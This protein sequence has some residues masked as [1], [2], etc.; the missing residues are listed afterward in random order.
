MDNVGSGSSPDPNPNVLYSVTKGMYFAASGSWHVGW[1]LLAPSVPNSDVPSSM[2]KVTRTDSGLR[3]TEPWYSAWIL[4]IGRGLSW[5]VAH[6]HR[7]LIVILSSWPIA[8]HYYYW[9]F[10]SPIPH[11]P[12][13]AIKHAVES[14]EKKKIQIVP[15]SR[16]L[17]HFSANSRAK[18]WSVGYSVANTYENHWC[19]SKRTTAHFIAMHCGLCPRLV[20]LFRPRWSFTHIGFPLSSPHP[21]GNLVSTEDCGVFAMLDASEAWRTCDSSISVS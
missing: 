16:V 9:S 11:L 10:I 17:I 15:F 2:W 4:S 1:A 3:K 18:P 13:V 8:L 14:F 5:C 20:F 19:C 21:I 12:C 7:K 6:F